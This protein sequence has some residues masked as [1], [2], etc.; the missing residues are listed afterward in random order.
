M[1]LLHLGWVG[2]RS[3]WR[4]WADMGVNFSP[5]R[6]GGRHIK[7]SE[8]QCATQ[9]IQIHELSGAEVAML[10]VALEFGGSNGY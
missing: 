4:L 1:E 9:P 2:R 5:Q 10:K 6:G 7:S 8:P 3:R